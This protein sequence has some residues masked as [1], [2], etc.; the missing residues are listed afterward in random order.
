M[1]VLV[2]DMVVEMRHVLG[3][4][5]AISKSRWGGSK[6]LSLRSGVGRPRLDS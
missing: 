5:R 6:T 4:R 3:T 2:S 1:I